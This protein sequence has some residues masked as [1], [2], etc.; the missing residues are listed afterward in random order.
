MHNYSYNTIATAEPV[1]DWK[2]QLIEGLSRSQAVESW[3]HLSSTDRDRVVEA[4][5]NF[6]MMVPVDYAD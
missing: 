5:Q 4:K 1:G 6:P 3:L 2:E